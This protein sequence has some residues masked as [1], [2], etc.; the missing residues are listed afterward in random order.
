MHLSHAGGGRV[1]LLKRFEDRVRRNVRLLGPVLGFI[2]S[3]LDRLP[4]AGLI[5]VVGVIFL[6]LNPKALSLF[7]ERALF[8]FV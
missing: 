3:V 6:V 2:L 5:F 7:H 1:C 4:S 8:T